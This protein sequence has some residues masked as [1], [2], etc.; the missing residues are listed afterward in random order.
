MTDTTGLRIEGEEDRSEIPTLSFV[1]SDEL[2]H[3][4]TESSLR[5][6]FFALFLSLLCM[7]TDL[8]IVD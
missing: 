2:Y 5:L 1:Y 6:A 7:E 8:L 4:R 3:V